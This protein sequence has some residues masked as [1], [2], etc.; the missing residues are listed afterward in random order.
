MGGLSEDILE[1]AKESRRPM[2]GDV[3]FIIR[4]NA[5]AVG[6]IPDVNRL[7][8]RCRVVREQSNGA[9]VVVLDNETG[10]PE[11]GDGV[12]IDRRN[13]AILTTRAAALEYAAQLVG[14]VL[15]ML[16]VMRERAADV[17]DELTENLTVELSR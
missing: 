16:E 4:R 3:V 9:R 17:M 11:D 5:V 14:N 2:P 13:H 1:A 12:F 10:L 15:D 8:T 6:N 7:I